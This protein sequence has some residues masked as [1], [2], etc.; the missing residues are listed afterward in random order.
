MLFS[1]LNHIVN[2]NIIASSINIFTNAKELL[3]FVYL[4]I[5][6]HRADDRYMKKSKYWFRFRLNRYEYL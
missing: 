2:I 1:P 4:L 6:I 5:E 3:N